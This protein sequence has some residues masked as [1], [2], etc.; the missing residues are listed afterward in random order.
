MIQESAVAAWAKLNA[1]MVQP[2]GER[3]EAR[4]G[5]AGVVLTHF[6][7]DKAIETQMVYTTAEALTLAEWILSIH[8]GTPASGRAPRKR[9]AKAGKGEAG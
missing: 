7:L 4:A 2:L 3:D 5:E 1:R 8:A 9:R 6:T